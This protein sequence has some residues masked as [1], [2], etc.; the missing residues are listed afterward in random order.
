MPVAS[1]SVLRATFDGLKLQA[2]S[3]ANCRRFKVTRLGAV[4]CTHT[5]TMREDFGQIGTDARPLI[6]T[7]GLSV[8]EDVG[9]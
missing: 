6:G 3:S 5:L 2:A 7:R 9:P 4:P 1:W 8:S